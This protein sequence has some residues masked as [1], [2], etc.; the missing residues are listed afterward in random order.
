MSSKSRPGYCTNRRYDFRNVDEYV[1]MGHN[2]KIDKEKET[3]VIKGS[4]ILAWAA[5][6]KL[7]FIIKNRKLSINLKC[8][9]TDNNKKKC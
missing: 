7:S 9:V 2:V 8:K 1:Y 5:F 4:K 3:S 6:G